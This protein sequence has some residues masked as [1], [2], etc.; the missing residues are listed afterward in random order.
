[1]VDLDKIEEKL[2][3]S[4]EAGEDI[5]TSL[6][7]EHAAATIILYGSSVRTLCGYNND[8]MDK[9]REIGR[10]LAGD[11]ELGSAVLTY[12]VAGRIF[13]ANYRETHDNQGNRI[14][15]K[16]NEPSPE[17]FVKK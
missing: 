16:L 6:S 1:M 14:P 11:N 9:A 10:K 3:E 7:L 15:R 17:S 8:Y 12:L 13:L 4:G 2:L 5:P